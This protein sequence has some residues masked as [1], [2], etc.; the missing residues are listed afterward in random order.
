MYQAKRNFS[1]VFHQTIV[2]NGVVAP[3]IFDLG[4]IWGDLLSLKSSLILEE[5]VW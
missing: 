2:A 4:F 5:D 3:L 1:C